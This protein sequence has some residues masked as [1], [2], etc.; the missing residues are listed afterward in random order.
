MIRATLTPPVSSDAANPIIPSKTSLTN[1]FA[2]RFSMRHLEG[3][4]RYS[5]NRGSS[6]LSRLTILGAAIPA[7]TYPRTAVA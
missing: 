2:L 1:P 5:V 3:E 4:I 7:T 6:L